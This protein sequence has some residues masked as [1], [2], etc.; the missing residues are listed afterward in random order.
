LSAFPSGAAGSIEH[1]GAGLQVRVME[2]GG[3]AL[4]WICH[5][6][7]DKTPRQRTV[8]IVLWTAAMML[9]A[10]LDRYSSLHATGAPAT[11]SI[12]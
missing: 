6:V 2:L 5:R 4:G 7:V 9:A 8:P 3:S 11:A 10:I 12:A 1:P